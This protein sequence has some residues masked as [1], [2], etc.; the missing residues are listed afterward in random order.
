MDVKIAIDRIDISNFELRP[1]LKQI[2]LEKFQIDI[3]VQVTVSPEVQNIAF[4]VTNIGVKQYDGTEVYARLG[5]I[6]AYR[7]ENFNEVFPIEEGKHVILPEVH[8][9]LT[10]ISLSTTR[11]ILFSQLR[12]TYLHKAIIPVID[13]TTLKPEAL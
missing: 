12:G 6:I 2:D 4:T 10:S 13:L 1:M 5:V 7:V 11:G 9:L 3:S 8:T